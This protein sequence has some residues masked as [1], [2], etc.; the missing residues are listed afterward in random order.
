VEESLS[1]AHSQFTAVKPSEAFSGDIYNVLAGA[2]LGRD[3]D[4]VGDTRARRLRPAVLGHGQAARIGMELFLKAYPDF[5]GAAT[6]RYEQIPH[7]HNHVADGISAS[8]NL[9]HHP[10]LRI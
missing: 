5:D 9:G 6:N 10:C 8:S 3:H 1:G 2:S 4:A 7:A